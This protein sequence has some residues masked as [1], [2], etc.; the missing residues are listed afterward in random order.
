MLR[1]R[2]PSRSSET[3][4]EAPQ[5]YSNDLD[6]LVQTRP[7]FPASPPQTAQAPLPR[8][9]APKTSQIQPQV[10]SKSASN[11]P[12]KNERHE[13]DDKKLKTVTPPAQSKHDQQSFTG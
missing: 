9:G 3:E 10:D 8:A 7:A 6:Y 11:H 4:P 2:F 13:D 5:S 1:H 12:G